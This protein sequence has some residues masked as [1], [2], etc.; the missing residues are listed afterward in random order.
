MKNGTLT[1]ASLAS[2]ALAGGLATANAQ[3]SH[4]QE[5]SYET[6]TEVQG[7]TE[8]QVIDGMAQSDEMNHDGMAQSDKMNHD[9]DYAAKGMSDDLSSMDPDQLEGKAVYFN[10]EAVGDVDS[11][12]VEKATKER[13]AIIGIEGIMGENAKEVAVPLKELRLQASGDGLE[14]QLSKTELQSRP[15]IDPLDD[16]YEDVDEGA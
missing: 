11:I 16:D 9:N 1:L 15:D 10:G 6:T 3:E 12:R 4:E 5:D 7:A 13:V 14:T 2:L 8:H